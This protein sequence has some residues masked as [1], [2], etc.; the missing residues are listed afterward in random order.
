MEQEMA[1]GGLRVITAKNVKA[2]QAELDRLSFTIAMELLEREKKLAE[3]WWDTLR[4][5]LIALL[6]AF[7]AFSIVTGDEL[8]GV[9]SAVG[10]IAVLVVA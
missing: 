6:L 1:C 2:R 4:A 9:I 7:A 5:I 10:G 3:P 8:I